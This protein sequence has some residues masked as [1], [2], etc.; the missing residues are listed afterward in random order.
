MCHLPVAGGEDDVDRLQHRRGH[1]RT[2]NKIRIGTNE[3]RIF[4]KWNS[5]ALVALMQIY[6]AGLKCAACGSLEIQDAK[7]CE[8]FAICTPSHTFVR[9]MSLQLR[10]VSTIRKTC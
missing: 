4:K 10:H 3:L 2:S 9:L 1:F 7:I 5:T 8:K 6:N